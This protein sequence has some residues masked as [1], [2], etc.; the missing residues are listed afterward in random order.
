MKNALTSRVAKLML[1]LALFWS[2]ALGKLTLGTG[3]GMTLVPVPAPALTN[4]THLSVALVSAGFLGAV[5]GVAFDAVAQ[6]DNMARADK[7][8]LRYEPDSADGKRL[9]IYLNEIPVS[10]DIFDWQLVPIARFADSPYYSCFTAFGKLHDEA[11]ARKA[12]KQGAMILNYHPAFE[13]TLLGLRLFQ[14]DLLVIDGRAADLPRED[15]RYILGAGEASPDVWA[16]E[17]AMARFHQELIAAEAELGERFRS[18]VI[19]DYERDIRFSFKGGRLSITGTPLFYCWQYHSDQPGVTEHGVRSKVTKEL[20]KTLSLARA[21]SGAA[22]N[23]SDWYVE[24]LLAVLRRYEQQITVE[25]TGAIQDILALAGDDARKGELSCYT[26]ESLRETI[27]ALRTML[28]LVE[29]VHLAAYSTYLT[30]RSDQIRL[31][32]PV[33]WDA[34]MTTMRYAALFRYVKEHYPE[35]WRSFIAQIEG[36]EPE[37]R[38]ETP[39]VAYR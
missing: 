25:G 26:D 37:P 12:R 28:D 34:G 30:E 9:V 39:T 16:N 17:L 18:F 22:F 4:P 24:E 31:L 23:Q 15:G 13:N 11:A 19:C 14:L 35:A 29:P 1:C 6:P 2:V 8:W 33:V 38:V 3:P 7:L 10:A 20:D 27:I 36:I 5:G 32:N 21:E